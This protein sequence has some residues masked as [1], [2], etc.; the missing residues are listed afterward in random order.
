VLNPKITNRRKRG[1]QQIYASTA[2]NRIKKM[3]AA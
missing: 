1:K 3:I 2:Q